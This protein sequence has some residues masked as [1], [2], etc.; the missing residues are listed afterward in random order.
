MASRIVYLRRRHRAA[1]NKPNRVGF[2]AGASGFFF[3]LVLIAGL[4]MGGLLFGIYAFIAKD[5]VPIESIATRDVARST[6]ILDRHGRLLYE[7]FDPQ[8]GRR[9]TVPLREISP[10]LIQATIA[11]E[12]SSF[13]ENQG[14]NVRG[15]LRAVWSNLQRGEVVQGGSSITQ[16]LAKNVFI[17]EEERTQLSVIRKIK[18]MSL[19]MELTRRFSKDQ[20]LEYYLNENNYGNLS[21]GIE[22]AAQ[23]YFAKSAKDLN[24]AEAALL[25]GIPQAPSLYSPQLNPDRAKE[26]QH[27]VLALMV[28][29]EFVSEAEAEAAK[30]QRLEYQTATFDIR[31]PHFV[32]YVR[33]LLAEKYGVRALYREGLKV[34]TTLD[35]DLQQL[36]EEVVW[37]QVAVT[38]RS[39]NGRNAALVAIDPRTGEILTMV[40][41]VDYFDPSIDGQVNLAVAE[42][43]PGSSFKPYNY[44][45]AFS[46]GYAPSTMVLD[47]PLTIRDGY[48]P[49]HEVNNVDKRYRGPV[50]VREALANSIN[51]PAVRI[52]MNIGVETVLD[53]AHKMGITSLNRKGWYGPS[54]TLGAG[55]VKLLDHTYAYGVFANQGKMAGVPVLPEKQQPGHR[56]LD[57]VAI[58]KIEDANGK[59]LEEFTNPQEQQI[60]SPELA[61]L[62]TDILSDRQAR[63]PIFGTNLDL[64]GLRSAAIK[65]GTTEDLR[66]FWQMGYTPELVV[67]VWMGNADNTKLTGGLSSTT[68]GPIWKNFVAGALSDKPHSSFLRP[69]GI[70]T[71]TVCLPSGLLA[72]AQ[73]PRTRS[74]IFI[75]GQT[76][77]DQDNLYTQIAIDKVTG[78]LASPQTPPED[79]EQRTYLVLP[80]DAKE[81]AKENNVEQ[82]PEEMSTRTRTPTPT[83]APARPGSTPT[84]TPR[85][86]QPPP[87]T[88]STPV[89]TPTPGQTVPS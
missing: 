12:D 53:T 29:Q 71:A 23:S 44:V 78:K 5:L 68:A 20:I 15:I 33:E 84:A 17:P 80:E 45:T 86:P 18:E 62:I 34:T 63:A 30:A 11:T 88:S 37:N 54:L 16:Q 9:T 67:G 83:P 81:W 82:P 85:P 35:L 24:L 40:G 77:K 76:P 79:V 74:D 50:S 64:P 66:D 65:T 13:Y 10:Y 60:I 14:I 3:S 73:C 56:T 69:P 46:K 27:A 58:L 2:L 1:A 70:V 75:R 38:S 7:I 48:N 72:T 52:I 8:F 39:I 59:V 51:I 19:S 25:A 36:G 57:P 42:R 49:P 41:S 31:A 26:R 22:A 87:P 55:E 61:Y 6:K 21:Y 43:Q 4:S 89:A 28:R 32:M 47:V